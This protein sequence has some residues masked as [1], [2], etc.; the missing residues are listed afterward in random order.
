MC[1]AEATL[2]YGLTVPATAVYFAVKAWP[3]LKPVLRFFDFVFLRRRKGTLSILPESDAV[4]KVPDEVWEEIRYQ[5]VQHEI[6]DSE[7]RLL[8]PLLCDS[9]ICPVRPSISSMVRWRSFRKSGCTECRES[10]EEWTSEELNYWPL[11]FVH[12]SLTLYAPQ[13]SLS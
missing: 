12:V 7:D 5:L 1:T 3:R 2:A 8:G 11:A 9:P 4:A 13:T 6:A 10:F